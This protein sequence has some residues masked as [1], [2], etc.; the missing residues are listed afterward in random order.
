[1]YSIP[2]EAWE[3]EE[4]LRAKVIFVSFY[5]DWFSFLIVL[6]DFLVLESLVTTDAAVQDNPPDH[7]CQTPSSPSQWDVRVFI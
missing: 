7:N 5:S 6:F 2:K 4:D 3:H 1:M